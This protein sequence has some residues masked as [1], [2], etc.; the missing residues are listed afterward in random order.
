M[1]GAIR[2]VTPT[3]IALIVAGFVVVVSWVVLLR[4][5]SDCLP[6]MQVS[7][8][9]GPLATTR[10]M[11]LLAIEGGVVFTLV[12]ALA[13]L[14]RTAARFS[15]RVARSWRHRGLPAASV[16][17]EVRL[18]GDAVRSSGWSRRRRVGAVLL[19]VTIFLA[20]VGTDRLGLAAPP[21]DAADFGL[22]RQAWDLLHADYVGSPELDYKAVAHAAIDAMTTA[23]GDTG[24]TTFLTPGQAVVET[25]ELAGSYGSVGI[26]LDESGE[27]PLVSAVLAHGPADRAGVR[28]GDRIIEID[29]R[30][31]LGVSDD[32]LVQALSGPA[33]SEV[34]LTV[35]RA[36]AN[37]PIVITVTRGVV[38]VPAVD[39][40]MVP[41]SSVA[42]VRLGF[43]SDGTA[44]ELARTL[45]DITASKASGIVLDLRGNPGGVFNEGVWVA[46]E[47]LASGTVVQGRDRAGVVR[48]VPVDRAVVDP[49]IPLVVLVDG[50]TASTAEVVASA[51]QDAGRAKLVG[52]T[53]FGTGTLLTD[54]GLDDGSVLSIGTVEWLTRAG[55]SVWHTGV[56]PNVVVQL[57]A[58]AS[59]LTP[60]ELRTPPDSGVLS[61]GDTQLIEA[62]KLLPGGVP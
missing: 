10:F 25:D 5:V 12:F 54:F 1:R 11:P 6:N 9:C 15:M 62:L 41:G 21:P 33:G 47:F 8:S 44:D 22:I 32:D 43:F 36:G 39:W 40:S 37:E 13:F 38:T 3:R 20:G 59:P 60:A 30:S 27:I 46:S 61:I 7:G 17:A 34:T 4:L 56:R 42:L 48:A 16:E 55:R 51:L 28:T 19:V 18:P 58:G 53:T 29:G 14:V 23:V 45:A 52:E 31:T 57:P 24:H 2:R 50:G 26:K 35:E 49:K